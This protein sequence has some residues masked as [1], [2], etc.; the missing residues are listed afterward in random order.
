MRRTH[1]CAFP[2]FSDR[3]RRVACRRA[4]AASLLIVATAAQAAPADL[5]ELSLEQ[6]LGLEVVSASRFPQKRSE[7][8]SA[9]TVITAA[10]IK[11]YGHRTLAD[12]L[13]SVRGLHVT[14]DR[15]YSYL[16]ARGFG[17]TGDY[18]GRILLLVDGYR[19][20]ENV[21]YSAFI[22]QEFLVDVDMIERVEFVPGPGSALYGNNAFFGVLNV[23]TKRGRDVNG[24]ELSAEAGAFG[25][26]KGRL[27]Y[28]QSAE[29]G[30]DLLLSASGYDRRGDNLYFPEFDS[31]ATNNGVAQGLDDERHGSLFAKLAN[32]GFTLHAA[33]V[34]RTKGVPTASYWQVFNDPRSRTYDAESL[35][36]LAYE[37]AY[38]PK[39]DV[40]ARL[41]YNQYDYW[42]DYVYDNGAGGTY[43]NRDEGNGAWW[44]GELK[45][46][47]RAFEAHKLV[48]GVEYQRDNRQDLYNA[49]LD[50]TVVNLD[51]RH[52]GTRESVYAQ[53][54]YTLRADLL[55]SAGL[56]HERATIGG[57]TTN[58]RVALIYK[59]TEESTFKAIYGTA[60]R[61][62]NVYELYYAALATGMKANPDLK[63]EEIATRELVW[64][65]QFG[66]KTRLTVAA[67]DNHISNLIAAVTDPADSML[68]FENV[69][70]AHARGLEVEGERIHDS[71]LRWRASYSLQRAEDLATGERLVN[72]P[73]QLAKLNLSA[74]VAGVRAGLDVQYTD[75]RRTLAGET[76]GY[77]VTNLTVVTE[78]L[79]KG[80]EASASV[81]N[82]FDK[83]YV[84]PAGEEHSMDVLREDGRSW[85]LKLNYRF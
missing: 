59:A 75:N 23:I 52:S 67:F 50:P 54:E 13:R 24:I 5:T 46:V 71:G 53:D 56:R 51:E 70:S 40:A 1:R 25:A 37:A 20:N 49:D 22:G 63:P 30:A 39:V 8:P 15:N 34:R 77:T 64:E 80:I 47:H 62:P 66:P 4:L 43:V 14:N 68:V 6:L 58:P 60:F 48:A 38:A 82:L 57:D 69:A 36:G 11:T 2:P 16:G 74:P 41:Y 85:R 72:S 83:A 10:D 18:N 7:A 28:G 32:N 9:V 26:S 19:I 81:Y 31:P 61:A 17:R 76:G 45:L 78:S 33:Q 27:T 79:A 84:Y 21:Y 35:V 44:G 29:D 42:G 65:R 55:L 12:I 73:R 3:N